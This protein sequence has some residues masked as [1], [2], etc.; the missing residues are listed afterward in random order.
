MILEAASCIELRYTEY[1]NMINH[2]A[3]DYELHRELLQNIC[4]GYDKSIIW[5]DSIKIDT[6]VAYMV[7]LEKVFK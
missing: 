5:V 1:F 6:V 2:I 7:A 3:M 4:L